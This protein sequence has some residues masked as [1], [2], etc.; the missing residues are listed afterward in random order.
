M[1]ALQLKLMHIRYLFYLFS[2]QSGAYFPVVLN[3]I[4]F[5]PPKKHSYKRPLQ[6]IAY[7]SCITVCFY[8]YCWSLL[9]FD[10]PLKKLSIFLCPRSF[11]G[12]YASFKIAWQLSACSSS[13]EKHYCLTRNL[14]LELIVQQSM[15]RSLFYLHF[16]SPLNFL[17]RGSSIIISNYSQRFQ[18]KAVTATCKKKEKE[19]DKARQKPT[20]FNFNCL[21]VFS[22]LSPLV[23]RKKFPR[24]STIYPGIIF[25]GRA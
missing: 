14:E 3:K 16:C 12:K 2:K 19:T 17:P 23:Y 25:R 10:E 5:L 13:T 18:M 11:S 8:E 22:F 4:Y 15:K 9:G 6:A 24:T 1:K 20:E 21:S 7:I